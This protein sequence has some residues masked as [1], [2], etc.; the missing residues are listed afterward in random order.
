MVS[1]ES[2]SRLVSIHLNDHVNPMSTPAADTPIATPI[3]LPIVTIQPDFKSVISDVHD[4]F[5]LSESIWV[6]CYSQSLPS[7]HAK[8]DVV[9]H[10]VDRD[11][12]VS[13]ARE[14]DVE[15]E[16]REVSRYLRSRV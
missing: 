3:S 12:V 1:F 9:L 2:Q 5:I 6:S 11:K 4:G 15:V 8:V 16:R 10:D 13:E 7:V 14:G